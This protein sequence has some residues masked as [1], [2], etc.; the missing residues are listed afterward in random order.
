MSGFAHIEPVYMIYFARFFQPPIRIL[1]VELFAYADAVCVLICKGKEGR[2]TDIKNLA[3]TFVTSQ[4][5][6]FYCSE[7][8]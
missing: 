8:K 7:V 5:F 3:E 1:R 4:G 6:I 2:P